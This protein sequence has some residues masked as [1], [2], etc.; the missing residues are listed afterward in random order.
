LLNQY[1][2]CKVVFFT[3]YLA[4]SHEGQMM[5]QE[6]VQ[7]AGLTYTRLEADLHYFHLSDAKR[8]TVA[9]WSHIL[10]A[11]ETRAV[12]EQTHLRVLHQL[13][14]VWFTPQAMLHFVQFSRV[15]P[16][17]IFSSSAIV[18]PDSVSLGFAQMLLRQH[19]HLP[20][21]AK[22]IFTSEAAALHWLSERLQ[23]DVR[24]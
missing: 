9:A 11:L 20:Q 10:T 13:E 22:R 5:T 16:A 2:F 3:V 4:W 21:Q 7:L 23:S 1:I 12:T 18:V 19:S 15:C 6:I 8:E 17:T 14:S 24:S